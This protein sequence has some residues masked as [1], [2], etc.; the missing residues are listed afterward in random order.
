MNLEEYFKKLTSG[1]NLSPWDMIVLAFLKLVSLGYAAAMSLR[2]AA[3]SMSL[4][5]SRS[6]PKPVVS[7]GNIT[8]GGTGKTPVTAWVASYLMARGKKVAVLSRGYGGT[9]EGQVAVVSDGE[10]RFL[11]PEEAGDEPCLLA[12]ALPGLIVVI[13]SNRFDAGTLAMQ[14]FR[15]DIFILDDGFQHLKLKRDLNILL[16]DARK[17]LGNGSVF[18]AGTLREPSSAI[19]RADAI[20]FTR[21][22]TAGLPVELVPD[23]TPYVGSDHRLAGYRSQSGETRPF[24]E[25][26]G[27]RGAAFAGIADPAGFF[28]SLEKAGLDLAATLSFPDHTGFGESETAALAMLRLSSK[29]DYLIT[30]AKDAVKL[31]S[32]AG[33][34]LPFYSA[35]LEIEFHDEIVIKAALD[36]LL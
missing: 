33:K 22:G 15:P 10:S 23:S 17:P 27:Q 7:I 8:V 14:R 35:V 19:H 36:K 1:D 18:P 28:D 16:L 6:L 32:V 13:G 24:A 25:L 34:E 21:A 29:A 30:T 4:L 31:G 5:R 11:S 26:Q 3:Y 2:A 9:L 12:D 20:V